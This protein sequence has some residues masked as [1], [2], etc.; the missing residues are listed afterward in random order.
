MM[1][2]II[3]MSYVT[4]HLELQLLLFM[5]A[6]P[7]T[8]SSAIHARMLTLAR[9]TPIVLEGPLTFLTMIVIRHTLRGAHRVR[10]MTQHQTNA[11]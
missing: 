10:F 3:Q 7:A 11:P 5:A 9:S 1:I 6:T 4:Y 8:R 2:L